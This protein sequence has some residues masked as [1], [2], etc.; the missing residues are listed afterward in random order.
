[1]TLT[2]CQDHIL[3]KNIWFVWSETS[4]S[5]DKMRCHYVGRQ[6]ISEDRATQ[7]MEA[8]GWV[9]QKHPAV[10]MLTHIKIHNIWKFSWL[11]W[12][13][14]RSISSVGTHV[15]RV[16]YIGDISIYRGY[17]YI[18]LVLWWLAWWQHNGECECGR[19]PSPPPLSCTANS[20]QWSY[21]RIHKEFHCET[22]PQD[23]LWDP[24]RLILIVIFQK[25]KL[26]HGDV[27]SS[28]DHNSGKKLILAGR[29]VV[30]ECAGQW[31][32]EVKITASLLTGD[33]SL[34]VGIAHWATLFGLHTFDLPQMYWSFSY[35]LIF[36]RWTAHFW[37]WARE[38][39]EV[40]GRRV[41]VQP[42]G[43]GLQSE[44]SGKTLRGYQATPVLWLEHWTVQFHKPNLQQ[45]IFSLSQM[46]QCDQI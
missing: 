4:Y 1:M 12:I 29:E 3:T 36:L 45:D 26:L 34:D 35:R 6:T 37:S 23:P 11:S 19:S 41:Q 46:V 33:Q 40:G 16:L 5:G 31:R 2:C 13:R 21:G 18:Y 32:Q 39:R 22:Y 9:S 10:E 30:V 17:Q 8:G 24:P 44:H 28:V 7:P 38:E 14:E 15:A 20:C 43:G 27:S 25:V 42:Q